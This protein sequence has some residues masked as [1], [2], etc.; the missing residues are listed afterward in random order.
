MNYIKDLV[1]TR[2]NLRDIKKGQFSAP[3]PTFVPHSES[4]GME[5]THKEHM[6]D[7]ERLYEAAKKEKEEERR[8]P[9]TNK[10]GI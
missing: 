7:E 1:T 9:R 3:V 8:N 5:R 4:K 6:R 10:N 2:K